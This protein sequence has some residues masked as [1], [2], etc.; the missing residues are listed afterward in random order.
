VT[1]LRDFFVTLFFVGLGMKI[2]M[3]TGGLLLWAVVFAAFVVVSRMVTTFTPL[4]CMRQGLRTSLI[5]A[6]NLSQVSEF[7]LVVLSLGAA[8]GHLKYKDEIT[9]MA[10]S[11]FTLLAALSTLAMS[12]S[13]E[14]ARGL[15]P[16]LKRRG[17]AGSRSCGGRCACR[18][19]ARSRAGEDFV[20]GVLS[21]GE[22]AAGGNTEACAAVDR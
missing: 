21:H 16:W 7:S 9:G 8:A 22:F 5:P 10:A 14:M 18:G 20:F 2:P 1:S 19:R 3:P 13:D 15:I 4:F 11:A 6:I 17:L 12:K